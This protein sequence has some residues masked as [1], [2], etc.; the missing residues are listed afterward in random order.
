MEG[1]YSR[2]VLSGEGPLAEGS[3]SCLEQQGPQTD[4]RTS[5]S[6]SILK[7]KKKAIKV[8]TIMQNCLPPPLAFWKWTPAFL[9]DLL[10]SGKGFP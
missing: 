1:G 9:Y 7:L 10:E 3:L 6:G 2:L 8:M 5:F 4:G